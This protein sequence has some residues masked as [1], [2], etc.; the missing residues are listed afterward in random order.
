MERVP[1][2]LGRPA[3]GGRL[4]ELARGALW[5]LGTAA[6]LLGGC[7]LFL[8]AVFP[9]LDGLQL[10]PRWRT[11]LAVALGFAA[12]LVPVTVAASVLQRV[13]ARAL[14][15]DAV[16]LLARD[17]RAP[18]LFLRAFADDGQLPLWREL[19]TNTTAPYIE[20]IVHHAFAPVGP[21]VALARAEAERLPG[22]SVPRVKVD[23]AHWQRAVR[24]LAERAALI[25]VMPGRGAGLAWEFELLAELGRPERVV[26]VIPPAAY[27]PR[28]GGVACEADG[29]A[30]RALVPTGLPTK[31]L[32]LV[33]HGADGV[34]RVGSQPLGLRLRPSL[35]VRWRA[36]RLRRLWERLRA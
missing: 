13:A 2:W 20:A 6:V 9:A 25:V 24:W 3:A 5:R 10:G 19:A 31:G 32:S 29:G 28:A 16:A 26:L 14:P 1:G 22:G 35:M 30:P 36:R 7:W 27:L 8:E 23:D 18:V 34:A 17:G 11:D 12:W 15:P 21:V 4:G 33:V